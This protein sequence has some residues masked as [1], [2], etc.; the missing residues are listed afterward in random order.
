MHICVFNFLFDST[1]KFK[2]TL[3]F[4]LL[5][6]QDESWEEN[7]DGHADGGR[8]QEARGKMR[9]VQGLVDVLREFQVLHAC[10]SKLFV[11]A[12]LEIHR[13]PESCADGRGDQQARHLQVARS[14]RHARKW[15]DRETMKH[16]TS[17]KMYQ[18][19][20]VF[21]TRLF[22][23]M[24]LRAARGICMSEY[25]IPSIATEKRYLQRG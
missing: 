2:V 5:P 12:P 1:V 15:S 8:E 11:R 7:Y 14:V 3:S 4:N 10:R 16:T 19:R 25:A 6:G 18:G 13:Q 23:L 20:I 9:Q 21:V 17:V 22:P 24:M